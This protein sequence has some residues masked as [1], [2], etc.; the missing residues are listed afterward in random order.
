[1]SR[2]VADW[3]SSAAALAHAVE[4]RARLGHLLAGLGLGLLAGALVAFALRALGTEGPAPAALG[5]GALA[6]AAWGLARARAVPP[7]SAGDA[8]WALDRLAGAHERGLTAALLGGEEPRADASPLP[9]APGV[10]L[11]PPRGLALLG[12]G[13]V[14]AALVLVVPQGDGP[15]AGVPADAEFQERVVGT[16]S[17]ALGGA[18]GDPAAAAQAE[19]RAVDAER[20]RKALGLSA[21]ESQDAAA[22]AERLGNPQALAAARDAAAPAG[23]LGQ[24][25]ADGPSAAA[26]VAAGLKAGARAAEVLET[27]RRAALSGSASALAP[28]LP[29]ARRATVERYFALRARAEAS[30]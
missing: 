7:V 15:E 21:V 8:A 28:P 22:V 17:G 11:Q 27:A 9:A 20:V 23:A 24:A 2:P 19:S 25:L 16:V 14:L 5:M 3:R 6:G 12:G 30:R 13:A 10:R 4:R 29:A 26:D 1:M 18:T